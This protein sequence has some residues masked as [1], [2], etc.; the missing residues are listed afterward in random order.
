MLKLINNVETIPLSVNDLS[1]ICKGDASL[2]LFSDLSKMSSIH[3]IFDTSNNIILYSAT[4]SK[5]SGH[6]SALIFRPE[7]NTIELFDSFGFGLNDLFQNAEYDR[8]QA[9]GRN[10]LQELITQSKCRFI[11]NTVCLQS[12]TPNSNECGRYASV[13]CRFSFLPMEKFI[14]LFKSKNKNL[15]PDEIVCLLTVLFTESDI[16]LQALLKQ[17]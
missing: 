7:I 2:C 8:M 5:L 4:D 1:A 17:I 3:D 10:Y 12:K 13:R 14:A 6:F 15:T 9:K 16:E 11:Y